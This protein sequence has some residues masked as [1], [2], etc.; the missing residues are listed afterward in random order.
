VMRA[1]RVGFVDS[2]FVKHCGCTAT[3]VAFCL[4]PAWLPTR[5]KG[6]SHFPHL[7]SLVCVVS[8]FRIV[9][10]ALGLKNTSHLSSIKHALLLENQHKPLSC[11]PPN[12][13]LLFHAPHLCFFLRSL[14]L[15]ICMHT[16]V[17]ASSSSHSINRCLYQCRA[18]VAARCFFFSVALCALLSPL[19]SF[20]LHS[21]S[22]NW[23][24]TSTTTAF[25]AQKESFFS[26]YYHIHTHT[27]MHICTHFLS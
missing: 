21:S 22:Q 12:C 9:C 10:A 11:S 25:H 4:L 6:T 17:L 13:L 20:S 19:S 16:H 14:L 1:V 2:T 7:F 18:I 3:C 26:L 27:H 15:S 5:N 23:P 24:L 8:F